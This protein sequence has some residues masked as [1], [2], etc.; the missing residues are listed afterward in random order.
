[1]H[2]QLDPAVRPTQAGLRYP[3]SKI[4]IISNR[5]N[6]MIREGYLTKVTEPTPRCSPL[7]SV[8]RPNKKLRIC[9]DPVR[10]LNFAIKRP[11]Y[12]MPTLEKNLHQLVNAKCFTLAGALVGF[13]QVQLDD[14]SSHLTTMHIPI[15]RV[16]WLRLP[17]GICSAPAEFQR[18]QR[19]VLEGL[20]EVINIA[21]DILIFGRGRYTQ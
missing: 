4:P 11:L 15:G 20:D 17:S 8:D 12:P 9:M 18:G 16:G 6:E 10:T 21:D 14:G 2:V 13:S 19:E 5:I 3:V 7:T 1:M